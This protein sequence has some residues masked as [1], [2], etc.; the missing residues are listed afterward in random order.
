MFISDKQY[1][2]FK[3][4]VQFMIIYTILTLCRNQGRFQ[5]F[6]CVGFYRGVK[7]D[8]ILQGT[9]QKTI[10]TLSWNYEMTSTTIKEEFFGVKLS[11]KLYMPLSLIALLLDKYN[12]MPMVII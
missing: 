3:R 6:L 5:I 11:R 10:K 2:G 9:N 7:M 4:Y 8:L 12:A 1:L